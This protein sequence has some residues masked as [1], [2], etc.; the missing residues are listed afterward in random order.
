[1]R[2][3]GTARLPL[4]C[5]ALILL[6]AQLSC[7]P[8]RRASI[9]DAQLLIFPG[10]AEL[11]A[12]A[13]ALIS[14]NYI[15]GGD[16]YEDYTLDRSRVEVEIKDAGGVK[17]PATVR[18]VFPLAA[19][20]TS[21]LAQQLPGAWVTIVL[22]DLPTSTAAPQ[23]DLGS[24]ATFVADVT[25]RIDGDDV[26]GEQ[27]VVDAATGSIRITGR[28]EDGVGGQSTDVL[29]PLVSEFELDGIVARFRPV[30][31]TDPNT[32]GGGFPNEGNGIEIGAIE[33]DLV[34][35]S[36][37]FTDGEI[38]ASTEAANAGIYL[39]PQKVIGGAGFYVYR[40]VVLTYPTGFTL[41]HPIIGAEENALGEGPLID[42]AFD[43][44]NQPLF[45]CEA[46]GFDYFWLWNVLVVRPDGE[47]IVD[48]RGTGTL[49]ESSDLF[50]LHSLAT[51]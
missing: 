34:Y 33:A 11:G 32:P 47:V 8:I 28:G 13:A 18:A 25:L 24:N 20:P 42:I 19:S 23:F 29:W 17:W 27:A 30:L 41:K 31:D 49:D 6:G 9:A 21:K 45:D 48:Q 16:Q 39:G 22:F 14:S 37:C 38:Y 26:N 10:E 46:I 35:F 3:G 2:V 7:S 5:A 40:R 1:M 15:P 50:T 4:V 43:R 36:P 12:S 44:P 51:P